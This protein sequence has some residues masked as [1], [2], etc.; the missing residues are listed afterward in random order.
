MELLSENYP[1]ELADSY[2]EYQRKWEWL[3]YMV[4]PFAYGSKI[5]LVAFCLSFIKL[6]DLPGSDDI[7][8]SEFIFI[9]LIAEFIFITA[10]FYKF[11]NFYWINTEYTIEDLQTYYPISMINL[12]EYIFTEKLIAYP[13]Q[14]INLFELMYWGVLA[15]GIREFSDHRISFIQS[16]GLT[17][18]TYGIGLLFWVGVVSFIILNAQY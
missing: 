11:V 2:I 9:A 5:I 14:L 1:V 7:K 6:T 15:L 4:F 12:R 8:F 16:F 3:N 13:L 18:I 17:A 10:G